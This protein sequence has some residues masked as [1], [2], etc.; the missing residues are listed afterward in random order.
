MILGLAAGGGAGGATITAGAL[1][2]RGLEPGR[3]A[4][5]AVL[6]A[7][8]LSGM[9]VAAMVA[10]VL[11]RGVQ[12]LWRRAAAAIVAA[13]GACLLALVAAPADLL[14][15][16]AGL[17]AYSALLLGVA[18]GLWRRARRTRAL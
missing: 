1:V 4:G 13:F 17:A 14:A 18:A 12:E 2:L 3:D 16:P 5:F 8:I 10:M 7:A 6:T 9:A 11:T 15:G